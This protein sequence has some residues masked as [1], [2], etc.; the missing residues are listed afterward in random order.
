MGNLIN[1]GVFFFFF[2]KN[3]HKMFLASDFKEIK[4]LQEGIIVLSKIVDENLDE[5]KKSIVDKEDETLFDEL[6]NEKK[7]YIEVSTKIYNLLIF[8]KNDEAKLLLKNDLNKESDDLVKSIMA[9][10]N[11]SINDTKKTSINNAV[12]ANRSTKIM[13]GAIIIA[14]IIACCFGI[15]LSLSIPHPMNKSIKMIQELS[16]GHLDARLKLE[17][18]DEIGI[19]AKTMDSFADNLQNNIISAM[20]KIADGELNQNVAAKDDMDEISPALNEIS[21]SLR[22]LV[23]ES[24]M[25]TNA[26]IEGRLATRGDTNKFLGGYKNIIEGINYTMDAVIGP[27]N[28]AAEYIDKISKGDIPPKITDNYNGDF[29]GIKNNLN[30][31]ID[32]INDLIAELKM[33]TNAAIEGRLGIRGDINKFSGEYKDIIKGVNDT[34]D[35]VIGPLNVAA[36][37][38]DEISKGDIPS[39]ITDNFNG[40]FNEIKGN[41][42]KCIESINNLVNDVNML[43]QY[44]VAGKLDIRADENKHNGDFK[45]I[46]NGVNQTLDAVVKPINEAAQILDKVAAKDLTVRITSDFRGDYAKIKESLNTAV[47]NLD[48]GL[49]QV[50]TSAEQVTSAASQ[51]GSGS[52]TLSQG[53][54]TQ[55]SSI[56]EVSSSMQ[57]MNSMTKQNTSNSMEARNMSETAKV[58]A[59]K[60]VENMKKMFDSMNRIKKSASDTEKII[61]TI[62]EIAFQTNLLALNAAVEAARA[63]EAGKGL[64]LCYDC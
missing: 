40:D 63:G 7:N 29:N 10:A 49:Q 22:G 35:A 44:A 16:K 8:K 43:V 3:L 32:V 13:L 46:I 15:F 5:P 34:M 50:A 1:I 18:A 57:E 25:L 30:K 56:E 11:M 4:E 27:I 38:I 42:N 17:R 37:F 36:V 58:S 21:N 14:F 48:K 55:A 12:I 54:S 28:V 24:K 45:K 39:K 47:D 6:I 59:E 9:Y 31:N 53:S 26:L 64:Y 51:I 33:L 41:L 19:L 23:E 2:R 52:Q 61:K 20:K 62:D 60:G